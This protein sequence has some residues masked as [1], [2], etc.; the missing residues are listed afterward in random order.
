MKITL[1]SM[2]FNGYDSYIVKSLIKKGFDVHHINL[3]SLKV[4]YP[5]IFYRILNFFSKLLFSQNNKIKYQKN[6]IEKALVKIGKQDS[7]LVIR[8]DLLTNESL[9]VLRNHTNQFIAYHYDSVSKFPRILQV[10][11][12]FDRVYSFEKKDCLKYGY[13]FIT[14]YI[15]G[16][17]EKPSNNFQYYLFNVSSNDNRAP[18]IER[19]A[20]KL[21]ENNYKF[22][23]RIVGTIS[24]NHKKIENIIYTK[25]YISLEEVKKLASESMAILDVNV[26]GQEGLSFRFFEAL[27]QSKKIITTNRSIKDYDFYNENN[28]MIIEKDNININS[29]FFNKSYVPI[30]KCIL[31]KYTIDEWVDEIFKL[32]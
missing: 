6:A 32:R 16:K 13:I 9:R 28:I 15:Y 8:A 25:K 31:S 5:N 27:S 1:V 29:D 7:I 3:K 26:P 21:N 11:D 19:I 10:S 30:D 17:I 2:D 18:L 14:N 23:I 20:K 12:K 24:K 4:K 22:Y